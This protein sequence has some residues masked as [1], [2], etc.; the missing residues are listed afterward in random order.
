MKTLYLISTPI[1]NL[2][3]L[4][5]RAVKVMFIVPIILCEDTR[6]TNFLLE[7]SAAIFNLSNNNKAQLISYY[8]ENESGR[9]P[10]AI[11]L[12]TE[13]ADIALVTDAGTPLLSDPG[14]KLVREVI[15][16]G[17]K[18]VSIPGPSSI[19]SSLVISGLPT[20]RFMF[21]GFLPKKENKIKEILTNLPKKTT[22]IFFESPFRVIETLKNL[23]T[24]FGDIDIVICRELTKIHEEVIRNKISEVIKHFTKNKPRGEF[25]CLFRID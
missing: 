18:V 24:N 4:S 20:D 13:G 9:I 16:K 23:I 15:S 14:Y 10:R 5:L 12:L 6:K 17:F 8:E 11:E 21:I 1:G 2:E 19:T 7:K 22:I 3:D 25:T